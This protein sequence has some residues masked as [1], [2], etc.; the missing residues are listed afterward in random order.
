[1]RSPWNVPK[2]GGYNDVVRT[3]AHRGILLVA[4]LCAVSTVAF[5][6]SPAPELETAWVCPMH[7]D[8]TMDITGQCPR[9]GMNLV[10]A[11]PFDVRDY[12]LDFRTVPSV[13][14]SG[15]KAA[16]YFATTC[17]SSRSGSTDTK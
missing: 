2:Q 8:F 15:E 14:K 17:R 10:R 12:R 6:Q 3:P 4:L 11:A 5:F 1:M 7:P 13:V 9:C 16:T